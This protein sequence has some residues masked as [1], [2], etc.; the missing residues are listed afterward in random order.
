MCLWQGEMLVSLINHIDIWEESVRSFINSDDMIALITSIIPLTK[1]SKNVDMV[2]SVVLSSF[3]Q[4]FSSLS[5]LSLTS[6][7]TTYEKLI[8]LLLNGFI[9]DINTQTTCVLSCLTYCIQVTY[10]MKIK[11]K[12]KLSVSSLQSS[13]PISS[14]STSPTSS[15]SSSK[16]TKEKKIKNERKVKKNH[17]ESCSL[18]SA[19][20]LP[21][22]RKVDWVQC[23]L[24]DLWY[25]TICLKLSI[26]E[27]DV[28]GVF[29]CP[30]CETSSLTV[31]EAS[32]SPSH[33][34]LVAL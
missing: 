15:S 26:N 30:M 1:N 23:D 21:S 29:V 17:I 32:S 5:T 20:Q 22:S 2:M 3:N 7:V 6:F 19:C 33:S 34:P 13:S 14:L 8:D 28:D 12:W 27:I 9:T 31:R 24:C 16:I 25:H 10:G 4:D 11:D 18:G